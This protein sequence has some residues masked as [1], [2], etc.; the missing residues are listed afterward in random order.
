MSKK[1]LFI[2]YDYVARETCDL[3]LYI[4]L[5]HQMEQQGKVIVYIK[6]KE[7]QLGKNFPGNLRLRHVLLQEMSMQHHSSK[8]AIHITCGE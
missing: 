2:M 6:D 5:A 1:K 4:F 3:F 8:S 7:F